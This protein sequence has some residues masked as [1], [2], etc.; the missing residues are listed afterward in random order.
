M[1]PRNNTAIFV[2]FIVLRFASMNRLHIEGMTQDKGEAFFCTG[3]RPANTRCR[4]PRRRRPGPDD[5]ERSPAKTLWGS[6]AD[7]CGPASGRL[8]P[9]YRRTW[10][11]HVDR[12]R[13]NV[14]A[15]ACTSPSRYPAGEWI[16]WYS[17]PTAATGSRGGPDEY[18]MR[19][20][21][22]RP[23]CDSG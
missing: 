13:N 21:G 6:S 4:Y 20:T 3:G 8:E 22:P 19:C 7:F 14:Y 1:P 18:Q 2:N 11:S 17:H 23:C 15:A 16:W 5:K 9:G 12:C 10:P